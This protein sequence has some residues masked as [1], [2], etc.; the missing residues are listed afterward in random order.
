VPFFMDVVEQLVKASP[1]EVLPFIRPAFPLGKCHLQ[2]RT[3]EN[4]SGVSEEWGLCP[5]FFCLS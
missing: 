3:D 2:I 4:C 5:L 1:P